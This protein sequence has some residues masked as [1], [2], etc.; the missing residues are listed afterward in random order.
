MLDPGHVACLAV[1]IFLAA[2]LYSSVGH[3]GASG[4]IAMMAIMGV[5]P[6]A[7]K[8]TAL[9]LN[10][11]VATLGTIRFGRAKCFSW[12]VFWPFALGA[13]PLAYL[14]GAL[15]LPGHWYKI[16][17]GVI[18]L[19]AAVRMVQVARREADEVT[20]PVRLWL[21]LVCGAVIGLLSGMT[22]TGGGIFLTPLLLFMGWAQTRPSAGVSVAFILSNSVC[23]LAGNYH[24]VRALPPF[25]PWMMLAALLGG[26]LGTELGTRRLPTH[27]MRYLLAAVLVI[28][29]LKLMVV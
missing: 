15:K 11:M 10:I 9:T 14:G 17:V 8:P 23:G 26:L 22:G 24:S 29:G 28:A 1:L 4:Y 3:A 25:L 18:L 13:A 27:V 5:V 12:P 7:M 19:Y 6:E 20:Q 2:T 16:L 21:A